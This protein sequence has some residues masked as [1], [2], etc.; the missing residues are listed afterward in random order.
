MGQAI[1]RMLPIIL[2]ALLYL[3][4]MAL[5]IGAVQAQECKPSRY[6][7]DTVRCSDGRAWRKDRYG[8]DTWR[9]NRGE[10]WRKDR[11]GGTWRRSGP[12]W[13]GRGREE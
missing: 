8:S 7:R 5:L 2:L 3:F 6:E 12:S 11:Y 9:S 1:R 10:T 4:L 13:G